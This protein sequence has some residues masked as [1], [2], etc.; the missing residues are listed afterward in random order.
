MVAMT[1]STAPTNDDIL[2]NPE[3][4]LMLPVMIAI[5]APMFLMSE[6]GNGFVIYSL[7]YLKRHRKT[8]ID[9]YALSLAIADLQLTTLTLFNG[10]EY[11]H[12]EWLLGEISC[13]IHGTL[14]ELSY[15]VS[16][17][18]IATISYCRSKAV[19]DPFK[20]LHGKKQVKKIIIFI[21]LGALALSCPLIYAYT[22]ALRN[23]RFHCSNTHFELKVRQIYYLLQ[24]IILFVAPVSIMIISQRKI[25][26]D[27][28]TRSR[29][30]QAV[31]NCNASNFSRM[32]SHER[33][34]RKSLTCLWVIFV[35][36]LTPHFVM[37]S[38]NH[39][40]SVRETSKIYN[41][42]WYATQLLILLNSSINPF[43]Y[44]QITNRNGTFTQHIFKLCC[45]CLRWCSQRNIT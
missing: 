43:L 27:L 45:C 24:A 42:F 13:K 14:V 29:T 44:Y 8:A 4:A 41:Q 26:N 23:G 12:N 35:C 2:V 31:M 20:M 33:R 6:L 15:T 10:L 37:R 38:I 3:S 39:F 30:S 19:N 11:L 21:W 36:C 1:N 17:V 40:T 5:Y 22:V 32:V 25:T 18:T 16:A 7:I 9:S 28:R 34:I